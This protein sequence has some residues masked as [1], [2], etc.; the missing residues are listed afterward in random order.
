MFGDHKYLPIFIIMTL[1]VLA[2]PGGAAP[3]PGGLGLASGAGP[4]QSGAGSPAAGE[5]ESLPART[6]AG[7]GLS[8]PLLQ[9]LLGSKVS[10][11]DVAL[12]ELSRDSGD[13]AAMIMRA[14]LDG[15]LMAD[16]EAGGLYVDN[17]PAGYLVVRAPASSSFSSSSSASD[18]TAEAGAAPD[19][20]RLR[21]VGVNNRQRERLVSGLNNRTLLSPD[22]EARRRAAAAL[23]G[24][25][26]VDAAMVGRLLESET[27]GKVAG[28]YRRVLALETIGNRDADPGEAAEALGYLERNPTPEGREDMRRWAA[29]GDPAARA[30][31]ERALSRLDAG[32]EHAALF[33]TVYFGLSL[34]SVL[35]LI[36]IGLAVTFGVMG[37]INMAHGEMVMLG[38]Y[39][40]WGFQM[41]LPGRPGLALILAV[42]GAFLA[43]GSLG[44]LLEY[45]V[46]RHLYSRP[47]ETLL[48]TYGIS[49]IIRQAVRILVSPNNRSVETPAFMSGLVHLTDRVAVTVGRLYIIGF[50][51]AVFFLL[52][53]LMRKTRLGLEVR[54]VTQNRAM[55]RALG[56]NSARVDRLTFA[57]GS[58][59]AGL[60]GV[61]LSQLANVG[62]NLGQDHI[63]DSFMVV[64]FGG[65]GNLWGTFLGGFVI[66]LANK[67]LEPVHGAMLAKILIMTGVILLIQ[68]RPGGLFPRRGRAAGW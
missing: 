6:A 44:A 19:P 18:G 58:G 56:V 30:A 62:P 12:D 22:T 55:A 25:A 65:V 41:L 48:A 52:N 9:S 23:V 5:P 7:L 8:D 4:G 37:V 29:D 1:L 15:T 28:H 53:L 38:A 42:P 11:R 33:E 26:G 68:R 31:A 66:G 3:W 51:L 24:A 67:L 47:L 49:L 20:S 64:V 34:G 57:L 50:C 16:R 61:A 2:G 32:L 35:V 10:D 60:A 46:V 63:V 54:A 14:L 21:R 39:S 13:G 27:D 59:V 40:V 43:A 45:S 36:G 17:G